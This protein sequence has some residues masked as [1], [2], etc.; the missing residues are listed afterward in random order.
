[1]RLF[2]AAAVIFLGLK[3]DRG[4]LIGAP[5]GAVVVVAV[6]Y[7]MTKLFH[8]YRCWTWLLRNTGILITAF[9]VL[10]I[11]LFIVDRINGR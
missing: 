4:I 2:F 1:M 9:V 10:S 6:F 11:I 3:V 5:V 8:N 7:G